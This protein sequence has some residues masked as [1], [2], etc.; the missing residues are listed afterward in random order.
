LSESTVRHLIKDN[1]IETV[2][3]GRRR[4]IVVDS[5]RK[6][7]TDRQKAGPV[8]CRRNGF[9]PTVGRRRGS[10]VIDGRVIPPAV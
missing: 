2:A 8:D 3:I 1:F 4:L 10:R 9:V 7:L 6:Y 5:Y